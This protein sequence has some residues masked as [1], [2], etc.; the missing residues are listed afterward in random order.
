MP[1]Y[2]HF[3][4]VLLIAPLGCAQGLNGQSQFVVRKDLV[5]SAPG[6][7]ILTPEF[8]PDG[9]F[10]ALVTRTY[11]PDG[12]EAESLPDSFFKKLRDSAKANPRFADPNIKVI[13]LRGKV[14][15]EAQYGW[16]PKLSPNNKR[17]VFSEQVKPITGYRELASPQSGNGIRMFDCEKQELTKIAD[18]DTGY[19]DSPFFSSNGESIVYTQNEAVNGAFGGSVGIARFDLKENRQTTL[20]KKQIVAA[21]P[22]PPAGP[23]LSGREG[24][25]CSQVKNLSSSFPQIVFRS[26]PVGSNVVALLGMPIPQAGDMYLAQNYD[27]NLVSLIPEQSTIAP[28]GKRS[29]ESNDNTTFQIVSG[30]RVLIFSQYWKLFSLSTGKPLAD[31]GP[32]NTKLKSIYSADLNYYLCAQP[33]GEPDHFALYRTSDGKRLVSLPKMAP[34]YEAVWSPGS[35]RFAIVGVPIAGANPMNHREDLV[36]YSLL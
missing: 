31:G 14:V 2:H 32:R 17:V 1:F 9:N 5:W 27:M 3:A 22:C 20:V 23:N 6:N 12:G 7:Q 11:W 33:D 18:P 25:V 10:L 26:A 16:N 8:S 29:M 13:D 34:I 21:V 35:H 30:E 15:C 28:L 4:L 24:F 36:I 19:L